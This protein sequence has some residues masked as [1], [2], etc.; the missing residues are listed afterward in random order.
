M[1][2]IRVTSS[3]GFKNLLE[4]GYSYRWSSKD[5]LADTIQSVRKKRAK[6]DCFGGRGTEENIKRECP[7][8]Y[9]LN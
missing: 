7:F 1:T 3:L 2:L 5:V 9:F 4:S 8:T 6:D